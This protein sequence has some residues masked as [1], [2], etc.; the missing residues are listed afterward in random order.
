M[1]LP[2]VLNDARL[3][4]NYWVL[5]KE[6]I[7]N[8]QSTIRL[9]YLKDIKA[10]NLKLKMDFDDAKKRNL[11]T[12]KEKPKYVK[13]MNSRVLDDA[14]EEYLRKLPVLKRS[15]VAESVKC[16][17]ENLEPLKQWVV[18]V[19]G[20]CSDLDLNV[21]AHW[22]W[23]VKRNLNGLPVVYHIMPIV[24]S[25]QLMGA[26]KQGG[27]KSTAI[28]KL[29]EPVYPVS[30]TLRM[31]QVSDERSFTTFNTYLIGFLDEMAGA[32]KVEIEEFKR[33]VTAD[34]LMYRPM[35]TN[36]Q[37]QIKNLCS[38]IGASNNSLNDIIKDTTGMRRFFPINALETLNHELINS[39]NYNELWQG[40]DEKK[41]RGY[42]E[43]VLPQVLAIQ[44]KVSVKDELELFI[45]DFNLYPKLESTEINVRTVFD[46]YIIQAKNF[47]N[48]Y[49]LKFQNFYKRLESIGLTVSERRDDKRARYRTVR[50]NSEHALGGQLVVNIL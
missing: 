32:D 39:I 29:I 6:V 22:I 48:K 7:G 43:T 3:Y 17:S 21:M 28:G 40:I 38:F 16:I 19:S 13:P 50:V 24:A 45:E 9:D 27:G 35:R 41:E 36:T 11:T 33:I 5:S 30:T 15:G 12:D 34:I 26:R 1:R 14:F 49:P 18:A 10:Y 37:V 25:P 2:E 47:G 8:E 46:A 4:V 44:E 20:T 31:D 42:F 23:L